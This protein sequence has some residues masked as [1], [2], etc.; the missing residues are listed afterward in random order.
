MTA[1]CN[2]PQ[3]T[4]MTLFK[5]GTSVGTVRFLVY[6]LPNLP[7]SPHPTVYR[8]PSTTKAVC[9]LPHETADTCS[10]FGTMVGIYN[11]LRFP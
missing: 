11:L 2:D 8:R 5:L 4:E 1:V 6:P 7:A 10:V 9:D 3:E